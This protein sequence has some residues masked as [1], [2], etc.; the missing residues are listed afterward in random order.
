[1]GQTSDKAAC[2]LYEGCL[3]LIT[4]PPNPQHNPVPHQPTQPRSFATAGE[5]IKVP[6][7]LL[8]LLLQLA[9]EEA[10]YTLCKILPGVH[11]EERDVDTSCVGGWNGHMLFSP[12]KRAMTSQPP[13]VSASSRAKGDESHLLCLNFYKVLTVE[14][15]KYKQKHPIPP[16]PH[17][18]PPN[19]PP[20]LASLVL[21]L[22]QQDWK[23]KM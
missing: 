2:W 3:P 5:D 13:G 16:H 22:H 4:T 15:K 1:M 23:T 9:V 11:G 6:P 20:A 8:L 18:N 21:I 7:L 14:R 17:P 19:K 12:T 10:A